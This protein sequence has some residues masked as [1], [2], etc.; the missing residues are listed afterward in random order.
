MS[1]TASVPRIIGGY[2]P[3]AEGNRPNLEEQDRLFFAAPTGPGVK[4]GRRNAKVIEDLDRPLLDG[5]HA[6]GLRMWRGQR[7][8][9]SATLGQTRNGG[10]Y[11]DA[12]ACEH[13]ING[14]L[15]GFSGRP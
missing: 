1:L 2:A 14:T 7:R 8:T 6:R 10:F 15:H 4:L 9:G 3:D 11:Y 13:I 5:S 12:G